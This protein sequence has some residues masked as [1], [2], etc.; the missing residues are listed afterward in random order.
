MLKEMQQRGVSTQVVDM[1][2]YC[3]VDF[4]SWLSGFDDVVTSVK[5]SVDMLRRHPL[6]PKDVSIYGYVMD[7][8]TGELKEV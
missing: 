7:S 5:S 2:K 3:G 1:M 6:L 4:D 8:M